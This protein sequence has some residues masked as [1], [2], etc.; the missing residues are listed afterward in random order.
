MNKKLFFL[1]FMLCLFSSVLMGATTGKIAGRVISEETGEPLAGVNV[2]VEDTPFGA[3]SDLN[4]EYFI[5]NVPP[6]EYN[7]K[8]IMIGYATTIQE[9]VRVQIDLTTPLNFELIPQVLEGETVTIVADRELIQKDLTASRKITTAA[10]VMAAPVESIQDAVRLTAGVSDDN[11]RGGRDGE[12]VYLLDGVTLLDP[13]TGTY[14]S[15][16]PLMSLEEISVTTGG[17][18]AEYG[19][20]QSGVVSMVTKEGGASYHGGLRY[21]TNDLGVANINKTL[22]HSYTTLK[23][24]KDNKFFL[25]NFQRPQNLRNLEW[26]LGGPEPISKYLFNSPGLLNFFIAGEWDHSDEQFSGEYDK[27]FA[28]NGKLT[29]VPKPGYKLQFT[30]MSTNRNARFYEHYFKNTTYETEIDS[31]KEWDINNL[32]SRDLYNPAEVVARDYNND[33]DTDDI[34]P[35]MDLNHNGVIGDAFFMMDHQPIYDYKTEEF[36]L[37]WTHTLSQRSF[38]EVKVSRFLTRMHYNVNERINEDL[39]GDGK[40]D[41]ATEDI[42]GNGVW[43]WQEYGQDTDLFRDE[44][45][46]GYID[47]SEGNAKKDWIEWK[48]LP[49]GRYRDTED[50]YLYGYNENLSYDRLRWN[51]DEKVTLSAKIDFTSQITTSQQIK[52]GLSYEYMDLRD[53]DVDLASGGNVYG[54]NVRIF[55][56]QGAVYLQ[57]KMEYSGMILNAGFRFDWFNPNFHNYPADIDDPVP[58][59]YIS[60][61]GVIKNP[62]SVDA[63]YYWS[64]RVGIAHP[65]TDKDLLHFSYG[66]YFQTPQLRYLYMNANYDFSGAFPLV[67]NPNINPERTTSY[68]IGWKHQFT[69]DILLNATG[70]YKDITGLTDTKQIYYTYSDYY[71]LMINTDYANVRGF[72]IE[73]YKRHSVNSLFAGSINYSYGVAKGKSSDYRQNYDLN[74]SGDIIP[75]TENYLDWDER[76][77]VKANLDFRIPSQRRVLGTSLLSDMGLNLVFQFGSGKPYSPPSRTKEPL[78]NTER[79]P[80]T[81][82]IDLTF[83]KRWNLGGS[84]YM[85]FFIWVN[86]L[87]NRKNLMDPYYLRTATYWDNEWYYTHTTVQKN[88]EA[89]IISEEDY[90][91][92]MDK[93]D[94]NDMD[95]DG[96]LEE[97]DGE[98]DYNKKHPE[99]GPKTD[100]SVYDWGRTIRFGLKFEF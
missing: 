50:F 54:Q 9:Q 94:P 56:S 23:D 96:I 98:V 100:P 60:E 78:I 77:I 55:P 25:D 79:L 74:W 58:E 12:V 89:G 8:A 80:Y 93:Q 20:I 63:K 16:I 30:A 87:L 49:F 82:T 10:E 99:V 2:I 21:S 53:H 4:G 92:I 72:E 84:K 3:A 14:E 95:G 61:G 85:S 17:F 26:S 44:N 90:I 39:N 15:D 68:E 76:H 1:A 5:L 45:D 67:G 11:F 65:F 81:M 57:D 38:Y 66:K 7:V 69:D 40:F 97:A 75:T 83:D 52:T 73:L 29:F 71:T 64:P 18:S 41:P 43:D 6:G 13:M 35:G 46:N 91:S 62:T 31:T 27:R 47:A 48:D 33:G 86:N 88:Y 42:N 51:N 37:T 22:G 59:E 19:N 32:M 70:Y 28:F 36:A 34:V 24:M